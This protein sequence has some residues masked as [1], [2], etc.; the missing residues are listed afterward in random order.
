[1]VTPSLNNLGI[2]PTLAI[3][4]KSKEFLRQG[5]DIILFGLGQSPFPVPPILVKA[6][7]ENAHQKDYLPVK[8]LP[9]LRALIS[10]HYSLK[11]ELKFNSD[12][13][14]I[15]PGS[16]ELLFLTQMAYE[17]ELIV[18]APHWVS[19]KKQASVLG[20]KP[21]S[22]P[23]KEESG[24]LLDAKT[25]EDF[26][27]ENGLTG[28]LLILNFPSNPLGNTFAESQLRDLASVCKKY[29]LIVIS[30]EI[31]GNLNFASQ[32]LSMAHYLPDQTII[33]TGLSKWAGAGGWRLGVFLFPEK[34]SRL[35]N[36]VAALASETYSS[37][38][39]PIQYAAC[40]AYKDHDKIN[41]YLQLSK[42]V[43]KEN[44]NYFTSFLEK[45][46]LIFP[47]LQGGFYAYLNFNAYQKELE[48]LNIFNSNDLSNFLL[49]NY[50]IACLPGSNFGV[51]PDQISVRLSLVDFDGS[52]ALE[53]AENG[54]YSVESH[55]PKIVESVTRLEK[56]L[57]R[58]S[59]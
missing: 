45:T 23:T 14:L 4:E 51:Q 7:Q 48:K 41:E 34:L 36:T 26:L 22:I 15:G 12:H 11:Y 32:H 29:S 25:L 31:Y 9:Q 40:E 28:A 3:N 47:P 8:G 21:L 19:Y 39:A 55:A 24:Y 10:E 59:N 38:S 17:N 43:L 56:L 35:C 13:I 53:A 37:V 58:L 20:R 18:G 33:L 52:K 27:V 50:L 16:K 1:M 5:K 49:D 57:N 46:Q 6:L 30:D 54:T 2:S 44:A 42:Y